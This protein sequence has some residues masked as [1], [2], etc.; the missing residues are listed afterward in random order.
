MLCSYILDFKKESR[1]PSG[2]GFLIP[3][4]HLFLANELGKLCKKLV[5]VIGM[6]GQ[7]DG[8]EQVQAEDAHNGLAV[9]QIAAGCQVNI[10]VALGHDIDEITDVCNG[11]KAN[12]YAFHNGV[13]FGLD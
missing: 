5:G 6:C 3:L 1:T 13:S 2:C 4:G 9:N 7:G 10:N 8:G 12:F 11:G